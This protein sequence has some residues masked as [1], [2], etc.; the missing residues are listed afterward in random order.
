MGQTKLSF[1][2]FQLVLEAPGKLALMHNEI[3]TFQW[4]REKQEFLI[5]LYIHIN[6]YIYKIMVDGL[7]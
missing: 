3:G 1:I 6:A 7:V 2:H 4:H 5:V